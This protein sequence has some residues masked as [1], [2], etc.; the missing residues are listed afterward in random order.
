M[1]DP[2]SL[3]TDVRNTLQRIVDDTEGVYEID[4]CFSVAFNDARLE[5]IRRQLWTLPDDFPPETE[6]R[7]C[8]QAGMDIIRGWIQDLSARRG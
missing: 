6:G 1:D 4:D 7:F 8:G 5:N 3:I 2:G